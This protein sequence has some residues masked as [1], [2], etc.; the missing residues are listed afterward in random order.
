[1]KLRVPSV[2]LVCHSYRALISGTRSVP[3]SL[4]KKGTRSVLRSRFEKKNAFRSSFLSKGTVVPFPF[5]WKSRLKFNEP[6]FLARIIIQLAKEKFTWNFDTKQ[7]FLEKNVIFNLKGWHFHD[8]R[9][10]RNDERNAI[11][12]L[13]F[14]ERVPF[15]VPLLKKGTRYRSVPQKSGTRS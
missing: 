4:L 7:S 1:M 14:Q 11:S 15:L 9:R 10:K 3:R 2:V 6:I 8:Y 5:L 13:W 12:F